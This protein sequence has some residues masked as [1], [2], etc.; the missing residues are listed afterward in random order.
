MSLIK[1][2][3]VVSAMTLVSRIS[4]LLRDMVVAYIFPVGGTTDAFFVAFKIPNFLRRLFAEGAFSQAFV[5]VLTEYKVNR[6]KDE[7]VVL[8]Q[9]VAGTMLGILFLLTVV[10]VVAS[11][12]L[13]MLFAPGYL[14]NPGQFDLTAAM[15]RITF[16]YILFISMIALTGG[17]L[18]SYSRFAVPAFTPVFLNLIL[19]SAAFWLAPHMAQPIMAMAWGVFIAGAVQLSFQFPALKRL[20][21]L[22]WPRWGFHHP[23]VRRIMKLMLPGIVGSSAMQINLLFDILIASFLAAGSISWLYYSDRL[24]EFPLGVFGIALATVILPKLSEKHAE[25]DPKAFSHML[26]WALRWVVIIGVPAAVA[27]AVLS[28]PLLSTLFRHGQFSARDVD[29]SSLSLMAYSAGLLGFSLV[30]VLAPGYFARQ[31]TRTPVRIALIAMA[32]NM[33]FN[34]IFV[35]GLRYM[36]FS[37]PHAGLA[38]ATTLSSI[39]NAGLLLRGLRRQQVYQPESGWWRLFLQVGIASVM[40]LAMLLWLKGE[41]VF[42]MQASVLERILRLALIVPTGIG[43]YFS[44]LWLLGL[45]FAILRRPSEIGTKSHQG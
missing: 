16:P 23:G 41:T 10:C 9:N 43:I 1:S 19:I 33:L 32:C 39:L 44:C 5:P 42:W 26:D 37:G 36:D 4:G 11:P 17:I 22:R 6:D 34:V 28:V 12:L 13:V 27:L 30:K 25:G 20:G 24:I 38:L 15:L 8:A 29:M 35:F 45:R 40:M 2:T 18:N 3:A 7:V 31:D 14:D 21:F